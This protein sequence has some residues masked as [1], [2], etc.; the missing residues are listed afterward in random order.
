[1]V[2]LKGREKVAAKVDEMAATKGARKV[3][4]LELAEAEN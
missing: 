2:A 4:L 1:M 3:G